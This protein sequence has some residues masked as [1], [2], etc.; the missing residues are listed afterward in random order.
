MSALLS[1]EQHRAGRRR[2]E[3]SKAL[4]YVLLGILGFFTL[5]PLVILL[6]NSLKTNAEIGANPL[7][8]PTHPHF[9][10]YLTAFLQ[11]DYGDALRN[12]T[13]LALGT[14][15][16]VC[17]VAGMAAYAMCRMDLP[18]A[19]A[20]FTYLV[21]GTTIPAQLFLIPLYFLWSNLNLLDNLLGLIIIYIALFSPFQTLLLRSFMLS[22]PREFDNAARLDGAN[23]FQVFLRVI[24]PLI[25][26]GLLTV[27]LLS[28]LSAWNEFLFAILFLQTP[29]NY[30]VSIALTAFQQG[31]TRQWGLTDAAAVITCLP[32]IVIFLVLQRR[33]ISGLTA[34]GL[35]K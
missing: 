22:I 16:G 19:S 30:P 24:L 13:I 34:G 35:G 9:D 5:S 18:G 17:L 8:I 31:F 27:G 26:P 15:L 14:M 10:N 32:I 28:G 25:W 6:F 23:E 7:G 4:Y 29:S 20:I 11:G 12:S 3:P 2:R 1:A 33:F 21:A